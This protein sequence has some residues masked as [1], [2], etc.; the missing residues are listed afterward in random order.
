M[1][2]D[3]AAHIAA[4]QQRVS[5]VPRTTIPHLLLSR[6]AGSLRTVE[7]VGLEVHHTARAASPQHSAVAGPVPNLLLVGGTISHTFAKVHHA[8]GGATPQQREGVATR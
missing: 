2:V 6:G 1:Q 7:P 5:L 3:H 4:P 8:A